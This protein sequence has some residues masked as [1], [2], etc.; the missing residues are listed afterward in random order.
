M[1]CHGDLEPCSFGGRTCLISLLWLLL[2]SNCQLSGWDLQKIITLCRA[3][4]NAL[5]AVIIFIII[6][7]I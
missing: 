1:Y 4:A 5:H 3:F 7:F 2:S 6:S